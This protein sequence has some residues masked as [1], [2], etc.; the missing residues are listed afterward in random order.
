MHFL[1]IT[2]DP[3]G[4]RHVTVLREAQA[5]RALERFFGRLTGSPRA[6]LE[7]VGA[8][9]RAFEDGTTRVLTVA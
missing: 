9:S 5:R 1:L 2:T 4:T 3:D 6:F 8:I 7:T